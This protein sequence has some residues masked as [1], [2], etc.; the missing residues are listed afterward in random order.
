ME[1]QC[2]N[3]AK[4]VEGKE[5]YEW[6]SKKALEKFLLEENRNWKVIGYV[7]PKTL[8]KWGEENVDK[9]GLYPVKDNMYIVQKGYTYLYL[10]FNAKPRYYY[11]NYSN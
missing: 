8:K 4:Q 9:R 10:T 1:E 5:L 7:T 11:K 2:I 3:L 6:R